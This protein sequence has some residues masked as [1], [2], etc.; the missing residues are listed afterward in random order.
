M[1]D[2]IRV[3]IIQPDGTHEVRDMEHDLP[4]MREIIGG[5]IERVTTEHGDLWFDEEGKIKD[6]PVNTAA[7]CLW[8]KLDPRFEGL[9]TL[10]GPV[11]VTGSD[12]GAGYSKPVS[13]EVIGLY[14]IIEKIVREGD[15][16]ATEDPE[17]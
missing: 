11:F 16:G 14:G 8:W 1:T 4:H 9:D 10:R 2:S 17:S 13:D 5:W 12:D 3:L 7:T 6:C 15:D